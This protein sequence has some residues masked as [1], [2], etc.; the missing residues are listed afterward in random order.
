MVQILFKVSLVTTAGFPTLLAIACTHNLV[1][2]GTFRQ[3]LKIRK[4][5]ILDFF[6]FLI[7]EKQI[8]LNQ[9]S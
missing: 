1:L 6:F 4:L 9:K 2:W 3:V 8:F 5:N 7:Q